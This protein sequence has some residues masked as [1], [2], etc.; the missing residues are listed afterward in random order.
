MSDTN[1]ENNFEEVELD[2]ELPPLLELSVELQS[3]SKQQVYPFFRNK[4]FQKNLEEF[5]R[6]YVD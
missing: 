6:L 5:L 2:D 1:T 4:D 3:Y